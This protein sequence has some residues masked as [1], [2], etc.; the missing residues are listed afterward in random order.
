VIARKGAPA[1]ELVG[2][3]MV[4]P[5]EVQ[6][7]I[8]KWPLSVWE[9]TC[10]GPLGLFFGGE[11]SLVILEETEPGGTDVSSVAVFFLA[12][13]ADFSQRFKGYHFLT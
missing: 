12:K 7:W 2:I 1:N 10:K 4:W 8:E 9:Q 5:L 11:L 13:S 3:Y 6:S